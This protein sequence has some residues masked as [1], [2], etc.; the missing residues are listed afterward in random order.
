[1]QV[2]LEPKS[3]VD[4]EYATATLREP[5]V[6]VTTSRDPSSRLL[7]FTKELRLVFPGSQR[8]NRGK[9]VIS[10]LVQTCKDN[11]VTDLILIHEHRGQPD[12]L[13]VCHLPYGPTAHFSLFQ[14]SLRHDVKQQQQ[15]SITMSKEGLAEE[16]RPLGTV[17]EAAPH[18]IFERF[19]SK[20]GERVKSIL[21]HLFPIPKVDSKRVMT[22][23]NDGDYISFRHHT[24]TASHKKAGKVTSLEELGPRF[25][26]RCHK[27]VLGTLDILEADVEWV[28]R[29]Y[30]NSGR[31]DVLEAPYI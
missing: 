10:Q 29:P 11:E 12:G 18:L 4:D 21:Q 14:V 9:Y 16:T 17:S 5:K 7:Q 25:E 1:V 19:S 15:V 20:I 24:F 23:S 2:F 13:I 27:I 28:L 8:L 30:M 6:V 31:K 22:F 3:H 26:M